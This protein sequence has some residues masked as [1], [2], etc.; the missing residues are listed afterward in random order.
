MSLAAS[1][2]AAIRSLKWSLLGSLQLGF[3]GSGG[4]LPTW[5]LGGLWL[6]RKV[7]MQVKAVEVVFLAVKGRRVALSPK[8]F[9]PN[10]TL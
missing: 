7:L 10:K 2:A 1:T 9:N 3:E 4:G 5:G 8:P 6:C